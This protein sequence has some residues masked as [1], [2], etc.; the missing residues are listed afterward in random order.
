M[1]LY[2]K[3]HQSNFEVDQF[4][5]LMC[6]F[7]NKKQLKTFKELDSKILSLIGNSES[8]GSETVMEFYMDQIREI[9]LTS[10][11]NYSLFCKKKDKKKQKP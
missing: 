6:D 3:A 10:S 8:P 4:Y 7:I 2:E 1:R 9:G 5:L 11:I